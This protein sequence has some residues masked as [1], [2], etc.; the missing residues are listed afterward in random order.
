MKVR[1]LQYTQ[2]NGKSGRGVS[3]L[4]TLWDAWG[5]FGENLI[6]YA[7]RVC[8]RSTEKMKKA[9]NFIKARVREGH[10]DIVEHV[11]ATVEIDGYDCSG[12]R[13]INRHLNVT[14]GDDG[15][16]VVSANLRVWLDLFSKEVLMPALPIVGGVAPKVFEEFGVNCFEPETRYRVGEIPHRYHNGQTVT[17]LGYNRGNGF[18]EQTIINDT[19]HGYATFMVEGSAA[20]APIS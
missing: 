2:P 7:G 3:D 16:W 15:V 11:W 17:L 10:L 20:P 9:P 4:H 19:Q 13:N 1:L 14:K 8:Y 6:E 18:N 5:P 12:L